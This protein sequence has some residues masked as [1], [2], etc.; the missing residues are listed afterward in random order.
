MVNEGGF[1]VEDFIDAITTRLDRVQDNLGIKAQSRPL[2][3]ALKDLSLDLNVFLGMDEL[4]NVLIRPAGVNETGTSV[5]RLGF[6]TITRSMIEENTV[7]M[8]I[9]GTPSL[10]ELSLEP[11][12]QR[13]LERLG[14]RNSGKL[15]QF[16]SATGKTSASRLLKIN[17]DRLR[18]I[19]DFSRPM[20]GD[21]TPVGQP[22]PNGT[23]QLQQPSTQPEPTAPEPNAPAPGGQG[24]APGI[25]VQS[26]R[27]EA[28]PPA[29][30]P[31]EPP[32]ATLIGLSDDPWAPR[33]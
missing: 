8:A 19:V 5:L 17:P 9:T 13:R 21:V 10:E 15:Q 29:G 2:T 22:W 1:L 11:E 30:V 20:V 18:S 24:R 31:A 25:I 6:T 27:W 14:I 7:S 32:P 26:N 12:E 28:P 23:D 33:N 4:G 3:Y 16:H